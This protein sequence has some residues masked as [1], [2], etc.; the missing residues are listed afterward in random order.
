MKEVLYKKESN[1]YSNYK[2]KECSPIV[3]D[4][5]LGKPS[6]S[7]SQHKK[8]NT[9]FQLFLQ[10]SYDDKEETYIENYGNPIWSVSKQYFMVV[11][12]KEEHKVSIKLFYGYKHR[13]PGVAWFRV[14]KEMD[15]ISVNTKTGDVYV[16]GM[17]N[18]HQKRKCRKRITRNYFLGEPVNS[19]MSLIKNNFKGDDKSSIAIEAVTTFMNQIDPTNDY[20][21]LTFNQRLFKFYL[22][23]RGV[24]FPNNFYVFAESWFGPEIKK[25]LKKTDNRMIDSVMKRHELSGKKLKK[26][27]HNCEN[28]NIGLYKSA[29]TI[30][31]N[32]WI[33]QEENLILKCLN[34]KSSINV[35]K[36]RCCGN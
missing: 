26:A 34:F 21:D 8:E 3:Y 36:S 9:K 19:I 17:K 35:I 10:E 6:S 18:Y 7:F 29:K 15:F 30:F 12:E 32:D 1:Q 28:L 23:K 11:V 25:I 33:N 24:K 16:G 31:G 27:L 5:E 4:S 14:G 20:G 22:N 2:H 13:K